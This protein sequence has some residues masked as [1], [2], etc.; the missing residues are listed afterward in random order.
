VAGYILRWF[1]R[2]QMVTHPSINWARRRVTM[3]IEIN[4]LPG[5]NKTK[6]DKL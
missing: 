4:V 6:Q 1:T 3:L 5:N 2:L